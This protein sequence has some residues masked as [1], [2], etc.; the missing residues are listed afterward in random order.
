MSYQDVFL[1]QSV[2]TERDRAM[3]RLLDQ[4]RAEAQRPTVSQE[5]LRPTLATRWHDALVHLHLA[6]SPAR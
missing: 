4:R 2:A 6:G 1:A 3:L 5:V